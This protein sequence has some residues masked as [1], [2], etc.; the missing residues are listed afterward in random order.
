MA[1]ESTKKYFNDDDLTENPGEENYSPGICE[2]AEAAL[3]L[4]KNDKKRFQAVLKLEKTWKLCKTSDDK[5]LVSKRLVETYYI[6]GDTINTCKWVNV[7]LKIAKQ[8][9]AVCHFPTFCSLTFFIRE[10]TLK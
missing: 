7:E 8:A 9:T 1:E 6:L 4:L 5:A 3:I 2:S 10:F